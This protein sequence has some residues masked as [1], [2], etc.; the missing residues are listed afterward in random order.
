MNRP[1]RASE[2]AEE[3]SAISYDLIIGAVGYEHRATHIA[4]LSNL[5]AIGKKLAFAFREPRGGHFAANFAWY[6][7]NGFDVT[8]SSDSE[9]AAWLH[10]VV[11]PK[12]L[13]VG[14]I[15]IRVAVDISC[16]NRY[17]LACLVE[18]L[19]R[20]ELDC[21]SETDF[22]YSIAKF[23]PPSERE[24]LNTLVGPIN[25]RFGGWFV[26]SDRPTVGILG[27]GYEEGKAL[28][29]VEHLEISDTWCWLP[30][31]PV[32][33]Y[34]PEVVKANHVLLSEAPTLKHV[35]YSVSRPAETLTRLIAL[36]SNL[37]TENNVM[38]LPFGPKMFSLISI[39]V[40]L[41]HPAIAVWRVSAGENLAPV[42]RIASGFE[43][44]LRVGWQ[45]QR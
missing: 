31:S 26:D 33:E 29:A 3:V 8:S 20:P 44:G 23:D 7:E 4:K 1:V 12:C 28:G 27:L 42:D 39:L 19:T 17:R 37:S 13:S 18:F 38:I 45:K 16:F 5:S 34:L 32:L 36:A 6:C 43:V 15:D 24:E 2:I 25:S 40:S 11:L 21:I 22:W 9:F 14:K 30:D 10:E 35:K 41:V